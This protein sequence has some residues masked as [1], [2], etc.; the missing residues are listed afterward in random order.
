MTKIL[1]IIN[2][3]YEFSKGG[4]ELQAKYISEYLSK[5]NY[6]VYYLYISPKEVFFHD[7]EIKVFGIK[8]KKL[9][10]RLLGKA[11]YFYD[12]KSKLEEIKPDI[13]YH[14]NVSNFA[15]PTVRYC[16]KNKSKSILHLAHEND[17][18]NIFTYK[19][20]F[21]RAL[22]DFYG[23]KIIIKKFTHIVAQAKYQDELLYKN[24]QR[25]SSIIFKNVH[26][27]PVL[28][29]SKSIPKKVV[30]VANYK[31]WKRP[32]IFIELANSCKDL[33]AD[34]VMI[35]RDNANVISAMVADN[36]S[37]SNNLFFLGELEIKNVNDIISE[38]CIFVNTSISEGFPNT[39]IQSWFRETPV[40]S[41][42]VDPDGVITENQIGYHS[43]TKKQLFKDVRTLLTND[44]LRNNIARNSKNYSLA[45]HDFENLVEFK[46]FID[47]I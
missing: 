7:D 24:F 44:V 38:S 9:L 8:K 27:V 31:P 41:L 36:N 18:L 37:E 16:Q 15:L 39:F 17:V 10:E 46:I 14:R 42:S 6:D 4:A 20:N 5:N 21:V 32:E 34:F 26:P 33:E 13:I 3:K 1:F 25:K 45:N 2:S 43:K 11:C 23:K 19:K 12:V 47:K 29:K 28:Y 22:I 35:G 40:V 30:W